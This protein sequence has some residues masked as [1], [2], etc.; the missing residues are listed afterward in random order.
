L[1]RLLFVD[2]QRHES[3]T[4]K[5]PANSIVHR[6]YGGMALDSTR[7]SIP[8]PSSFKR[9]ILCNLVKSVYFSAR[10]GKFYEMER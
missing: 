5:G 6:Y 7:D 8:H 4:T 10:N 2:H 3:Q 9:Y 1:A